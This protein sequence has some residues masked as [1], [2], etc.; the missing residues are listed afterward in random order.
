M[1]MHNNEM[2]SEFIRRSI[3]LF[4]ERKT[5]QGQV[6]TL[7]GQDLQEQE[8]CVVEP[9]HRMFKGS[10]ERFFAF[11]QADLDPRDASSH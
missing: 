2:T 1:N 8:D 10:I 6:S 11:I 5:E 9:S 4:Y 7:N 3:Q